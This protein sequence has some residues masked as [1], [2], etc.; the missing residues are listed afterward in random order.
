MFIIDRERECNFIYW[1]SICKLTEN[2]SLALLSKMICWN[3]RK[4]FCH[5]LIKKELQIVFV[6]ENDLLT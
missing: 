3:N 6:I 1:L 4:L 5:M 2:F